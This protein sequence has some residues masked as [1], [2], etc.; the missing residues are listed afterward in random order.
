M[1]GRM[2]FMNVWTMISGLIALYILVFLAA[3]AGSVLFGCAVYNDAK[4]KWNDNATM[5]GVLVGILGLIPGIIYLCVRNEPLKRIYVCHNCGWG[6]PL[7]AQQCGHC[8]AGLYYP[9]EET[10]QRQKKAKTLLIWGIVMWVVM[11]LAFISI[12]IVM[13]TM[14]PA[15][16]E[17]NIY[18]LIKA[19]QGRIRRSPNGSQAAVKTE[20]KRKTAGK[21]PAQEPL[22]GLPELLCPGH[23]S[24]AGGCL[25]SFTWK[26]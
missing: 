17:G 7:S 16:A 9:T 18:L 2:V 12:F 3:V 5:W 10:L 21:Q 26:L 23:F 24:A 25:N 20:E 8:G 22:S 1:I 19:S 6:N 13:F 15:I 14:I 4:S 11:I